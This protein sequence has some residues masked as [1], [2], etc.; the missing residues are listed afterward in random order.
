MLHLDEGASG[1]VDPVDSEPFGEARQLSGEI[2]VANE[3]RRSGNHEQQIFNQ[4][5]ERAQQIDGFLLAVGASAIAL[6]GVEKGGV[7]RLAQRSAQNDECIFAARKLCREIE[8][9]RA[10]DCALSEARRQRAILRLELWA[11]AREKRF[12]IGCGQTRPGDAPRRESEWWA[13]VP[14]DFR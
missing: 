1:A 11:A 5:G 2:D 7:I 12:E 9:E 4:A 10:A 8:R 13:A 14:A 6:G 3:R